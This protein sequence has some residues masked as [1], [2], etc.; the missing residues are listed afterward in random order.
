[1]A[2]SYAYVA[3]LDGGLQIFDVSNPASVDPPD[4]SY[5]TGS[6][7]GVAV[8]GSYAF[9]AAYDNGLQILDVS[10][11]EDPSCVGVGYDLPVGAA[12]MGVAVAGS[13]AYVAAYT[14]LRIIRLGDN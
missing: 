12:G 14:G 8:A 10:A 9:V 6:T 2:G 11:P 3:D 13:Y 4:G 1:V 5:A 7:Y